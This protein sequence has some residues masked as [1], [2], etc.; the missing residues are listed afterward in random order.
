[1]GEP[2]CFSQNSGLENFLEKR[3]AGREGG[4]VSRF[5]VEIFISPVSKKF[6]GGSFCDSFISGIEKFQCK[7][8]GIRTFR[9]K[10]L[11]L[12]QKFS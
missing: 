9:H 6:L 3:M 5:S 8:G 12:C 7:R 1:M 4:G 11:S 2:F 10:I